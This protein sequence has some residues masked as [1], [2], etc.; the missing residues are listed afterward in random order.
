MTKSSIVQ[1]L[2]ENNSISAEEA[3]VLL[4]SDI[5]SIPTY[6]PNPYYSNPN[7]TVPPV[8]CENPTTS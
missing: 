8:W 1:K 4:Q 2:L 6:T 7:Y 5:V 3:V